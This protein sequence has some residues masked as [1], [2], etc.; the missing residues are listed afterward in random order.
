[1]S[2]YY[3]TLGVD[4][5]ASKEDIKKAYRKLSMKYHPDRNP[6][7]PEAETKFK[8][9]SE[10]YSILNNDEKRQQYDNPGPF[11][12]GGFP[13]GF[14]F[15]FGQRPRPQKPDL[16]APQDGKFIILEVELPLR[17]FIFG[18]TF[19]A[20][21]SFHEGCNDCG[22]K[23]FAEG[24]ECDVCHG[25]GYVEQVERRPGFVS[26]ATR[27]CHKCGGLGQ[28]AT[29]PCQSCGGSRRHYV[30]NREI[31]FD[32]PSGAGIGARFISHGSGR[33]GLNGGRTGDVGIIITNIKRPELNKLTPNNIE[34]LKE[35]LGA[36]EDS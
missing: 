16:N 31:L 15:G 13:S 8:E 3:E 21:I 26:H 18:G 28:M 6:D 35:L 20:K 1:M 2:D 19:K 9:I 29:E 11:G 30:E 25:N 36:L 10:A 17:L 5:S 34:Q 12:G 14:P 24:Q 22:G 27:P 33:V 4:R 7:N 32:I 23:G